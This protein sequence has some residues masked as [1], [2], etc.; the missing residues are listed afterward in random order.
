MNRILA[1]L[2]LLV[3]AA[4]AFSQ[5]LSNPAALKE[6]APPV[7][8]VD[9]DT[10]KTLLHQLNVQMQSTLIVYHGAKETGRATGITDPDAI[11]KLLET[12]KI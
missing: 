4:P 7:Y 6:Q 10:S 9:F 2:L 3:S 11:R 5:A 1:F 8:R 12:S